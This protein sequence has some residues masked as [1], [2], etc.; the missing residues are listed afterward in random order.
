MQ[1]QKKGKAI[2]EKGKYIHIYRSRQKTAK[3][4]VP[5]VI[6]KNLKLYLKDW[7]GI[8]EMILIVHMKLFG[9]KTAICPNK[10]YYT[11]NK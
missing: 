9:K 1:N 7:E 10:W 3:S 5:I 11:P 4:E 8:N 2:E 6:Q